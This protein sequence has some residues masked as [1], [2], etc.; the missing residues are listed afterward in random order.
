MDTPDS[1]STHLDSA[2]MEFYRRQELEQ[3]ADGEPVD[4][5]EVLKSELRSEAAAIIRGFWQSGLRVVAF[6][7]GNKLMVLDAFFFAVG[8]VKLIGEDANG[9]P[10]DNA[11]KIAAK[12]GVTKQAVSKVVGVIQDAFEIDGMPGKR[13]DSG[14]GNMILARLDQLKTR[15]T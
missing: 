11:E 2:A 14:R 7:D 10:I 1:T 8:F 12:H 3:G 9:K 4:E 13:S 6:S 5:L 15:K